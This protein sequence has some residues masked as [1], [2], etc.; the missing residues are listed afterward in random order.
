MTR[1]ELKSSVPMRR[2]PEVTAEVV[3][4]ADIPQPWRVQFWIALA[5]RTQ[6][7]ISPALGPCACADDWTRWIN[8]KA[9]FQPTDLDE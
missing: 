8:G 9:E 5:G 6:A 2:I 7:Y 3:A 4:L 1:D